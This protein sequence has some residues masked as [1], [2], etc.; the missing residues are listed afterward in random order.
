MTNQMPR[1]L[2]LPHRS[3]SPLS[4]CLI[5]RH[6][7]FAKSKS[8]LN[9]RLKLA[10]AKLAMILIIMIK[11]VGRGSSTQAQAEPEL[12]EQAARSQVQ[13]AGEE[14]DNNLRTCFLHS[15]PHCLL[16]ASSSFRLWV[17]QSALNSWVYQL[18]WGPQI[19]VKYL[20]IQV[21]GAAREIVLEWAMLN[22][23]GEAA[24]WGLCFLYYWKL[25][26][27]VKKKPF[28]NCMQIWAARKFPALVSWPYYYPLYRER[29]T[30]E[31]GERE[32]VSG[33]N[34]P[35][36]QLSMGYLFIF[37]RAPTFIIFGI[38]SYVWWAAPCLFTWALYL[39]PAICLKWQSAPSPQML[40][41]PVLSRLLSRRAF[42]FIACAMA[43]PTA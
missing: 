3:F 38:F 15:S 34:P 24:G 39:L 36:A 12:A 17:F 19:G 18:K 25:C 16:V 40:L 32:C 5:T 42:L 21:V 41:R 6:R 37:F 4:N 29:G 35:L 30:G 2:W 11:R 23:V 26:Q 33:A 43:T 10:L 13:V 22:R 31:E 20:S 9:R 7:L 27:Q 8:K 28:R 14:E 1:S